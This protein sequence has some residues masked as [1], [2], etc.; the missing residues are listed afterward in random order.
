MHGKIA[1]MGVAKVAV[2]D[3]SD[4]SRCISTRNQKKIALRDR[5]KRKESEQLKVVIRSDMSS[6]VTSMVND[7]SSCPCRRSATI[8]EQISTSIVR[9]LIAIPPKYVLV[10]HRAHRLVVDM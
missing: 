7:E 9:P 2:M 8:K 4:T 6:C 1:V 5:A 10:L 3:E